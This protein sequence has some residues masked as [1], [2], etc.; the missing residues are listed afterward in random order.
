[1][2]YAVI[3][4]R[5]GPRVMGLGSLWAFV[6]AAGVVAE[7][8]ME[9]DI[10]LASEDDAGQIQAIYLPIVKE[11]CISFEG[12]APS[13][14][15]MRSRIRAVTQTFPWLVCARDEEI[16]G[17]A[18]ASKHRE[19]AAYQWSV[20]VSVYVHSA[21][22][23]RGIGQALYRPLFQILAAQGFC[24]AYAGITLPNPGSIRLHEK[25]GFTHVCTYTEVGFKHGEWRDVGWW[26][27]ALRAKQETPAQPVALPALLSQG[28]CTALTLPGASLQDSGNGPRK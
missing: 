15:D 25:M 16:L 14:D 2:A 21:H 26:Y 6:P 4:G 24:N 10:R 19:R 9:A 27:L 23:A 18:Y 8:L 13:V 7:D 22:R 12:D 5:T 28:E 17:Y 20:D 3:L 11:T 1:V